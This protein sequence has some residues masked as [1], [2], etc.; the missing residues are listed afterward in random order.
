MVFGLA[1]Y[2]MHAA[3]AML[4]HDHFLIGDTDA[5]VCSRQGADGLLR[6]M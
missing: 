5:A 4:R 6:E 3:F 2:A 1:V